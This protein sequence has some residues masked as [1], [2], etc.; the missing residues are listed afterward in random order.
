MTSSA[1]VFSA[2]VLLW[3]AM[4][5]GSRTKHPLVRGR[6]VL[7][8][9]GNGFMGADTVH[10]FIRNGDNVTMVSRGN[11]YWDSFN[12]IKPYVRHISCDRKNG[13]D[14]CKELVELVNNTERFDAV[15]DFSAYDEKETKDSGLLLNGKVGLYILISTDSIYDVCDK[16]HDA[17]T[18]EDDDSRPEDVDEWNRLVIV[19]DYGHRKLR[20]EEE[21]VK[22]RHLDGGYPYVILRLPDVIGPRDSTYRWWMYQLWIRLEDELPTKPVTIPHFLKDYHMSLVYSK[23][24][25]KLIFDLLQMDDE[26]HDEAFN[27]AYDETWTLEE[28]LRAIG[29]KL[30]VDELV[31]GEEKYHT[32]SLYL[33]PSVRRGPI[34]V[35]KAKEILGWQTTP[36]ERAVEEIVNFYEDAMTG[37]TFYTQKDEVIQSLVLRLYYDNKMEFYDAVEK[38][39]NISLQ[40]FKPKD[41]L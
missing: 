19:H 39:Y 11:W 28:L 32:K 21:L 41:E 14:S 31:I 13:I 3:V 16:K 17:K 33:Y 40:H 29:R 10:H 25:A 15:V 34:D 30:G 24:V 22:Q 27:L 1:L 8:F 36:F 18:K 7:V 9:G 4:V 20:A 35:A 6:N 12:R 2:S 26:I 37:E 38:V 23:D 5:T